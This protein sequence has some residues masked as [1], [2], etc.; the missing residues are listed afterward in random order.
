M[1]YIDLSHG[2]GGKHFNELLEDIILPALGREQNQKNDGAILTPAPGRLVMTTDAHVITPLQF[3]GGDIGTLGFCGTVN[4]LAMMGARPLYL[5][6]SLI[7]EE[8]FAIETLK[9]V[10]S[11]FGKY[12]AEYS[13]P[14]IA[15]DTKVVERGKADG[16]F[17]SVAGVGVIENEQVHLAPERITEDSVIIVNGSLGDHAIAIMSEREGLSFDTE[18][19][20]D[21]AP[22]HTTALALLEE[23]PQI[24]CMRDVTR[25]GLA[26]VL[27]EISHE[28]N[29]SFELNENDIPIKPAVKSACDLLGLDPLQ[30]AN[31]GKFI[32]FVPKELS[33]QALSYLKTLPNGKDGQIIGETIMQQRAAVTLTTKLGGSRL[34]AWPVGEQLPRIC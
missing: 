34:V 33:E 1:N 29:L 21:C 6:L 32:M 8:G 26:S 2:A 27:N 7:I 4:D 15:G 23:F 9:E 12:Q 16:L 5:S 18:V 14:V 10:L 17:L 24:Q 25:G 13:I 28:S 3:K 20:S 31:E 19:K 11:S 22:L 30:L